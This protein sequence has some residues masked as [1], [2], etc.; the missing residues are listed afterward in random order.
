MC[1]AKTSAGKAFTKAL[2]TPSFQE[3]LYILVSLSRKLPVLLCSS[4][5][6]NLPDMLYC[7]QEDY[8]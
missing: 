8:V 5:G 3:M 6:I 7:A 2:A 4:V 1:S